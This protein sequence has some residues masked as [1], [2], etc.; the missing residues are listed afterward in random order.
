[1]FYTNFKPGQEAYFYDPAQDVVGRGK[2]VSITATTASQDSLYSSKEWT[3][4]Y[5]VQDR[6]GNKYTFTDA[7]LHKSSAEA[8]PPE[9]DMPA[10][11]EG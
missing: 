8:W 4:N 2:I 9:P 10:T 1:M 7:G 6:A 5:V 11:L 3:I